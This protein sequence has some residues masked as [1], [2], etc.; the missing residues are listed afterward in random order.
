MKKFSIEK[1]LV[2]YQLISGKV[3]KYRDKMRY[4]ETVQKD[5]TNRVRAT[6][7]VNLSTL[8]DERQRDKRRV[9]NNE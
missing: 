2:E 9:V 5:L 3:E 4:W 1:F 7:N 8:S 6:L